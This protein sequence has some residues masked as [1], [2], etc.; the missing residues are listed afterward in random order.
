MG[1]TKVVPGTVEEGERSREDSWGRCH[2]AR[3]KVRRHSRWRKEPRQTRD[4]SPAFSMSVTRLIRDVILEGPLRVGQ[5]CYTQGLEEQ[6]EG[7]MCG[8]S[9]AT[10]LGS[11]LG[12][13]VS[14][15]RASVPSFES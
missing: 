13:V 5:G 15:P 3:K 10:Q 9:S 11:D 14:L 7:L 6:Q 8:L 4:T 12:Q 1:G 2:Q